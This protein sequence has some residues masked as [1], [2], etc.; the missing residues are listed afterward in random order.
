M[1]K[2]QLNACVDYINK[3][4]ARLHGVPEGNKDIGDHVIVDDVASSAL[5]GDTAVLVVNRGIK[6]TPKYVLGLAEV[7]AGKAPIKSSEAVELEAKKVDE[8]KARIGR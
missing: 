3:Y 1:D 5:H 2:K 6:G 7:E 4:A 8:V